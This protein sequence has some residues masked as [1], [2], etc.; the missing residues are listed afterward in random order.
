MYNGAVDLGGTRHGSWSSGRNLL[1]VATAVVVVA[2]FDCDFGLVGITGHLCL[3][4]Q[5]RI[6]APKRGRF[7]VIVGQKQKEDIRISKA[8]AG[9]EAH[10]RNKIKEA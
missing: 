8:S 2:I 3:L 6:S 4:V 7:R 5:P 1:L 10:V 9:S